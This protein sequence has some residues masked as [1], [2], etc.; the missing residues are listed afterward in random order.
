MPYTGNKLAK[1]HG[2]I[3]ILT[4]FRAGYCFWLTHCRYDRVTAFHFPVAKYSMSMTDSTAFHIP[5]SIKMSSFTPTNK[6]ETLG[7]QHYVA[8]P[9]THVVHKKLEKMYESWDWW[10]IDRSLLLWSIRWDFRMY[11]MTHFCTCSLQAVV[12]V[13]EPQQNKN[14][15]PEVATRVEWW[16]RGASGLSELC[17]TEMCSIKISL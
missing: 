10:L 7:I 3:I 11:A 16:F 4:S 13:A 2:N 6:P 8:S 12:G 15:Q 14:N 17:Y 5:F 9:I 1:F